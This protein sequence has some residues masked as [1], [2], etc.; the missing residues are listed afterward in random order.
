[1]RF[2]EIKMKT[3]TFE[4][5][6]NVE[7]EQ[8]RATLSRAKVLA[9][10]R[11]RGFDCERIFETV[12]RSCGP[13]H[14]LLLTSTVPNGQGGSTSDM[15]FLAVIDTDDDHRSRT[16]EWEV[17]DGCRIGVTYVTS[18]DVKRDLGLLAEFEALTPSA[19]KTVEGGMRRFHLHWR[20]LERLVNG[21]SFENGHP[22]E[23]HGPNLCR[24][25]LVRALCRADFCLAVVR[26][27]SVAGKPYAA[28][29][30]AR[31]AILSYIEAVLA[32]AG[33]VQSNSKWLIQRWTDILLP[34]S[35]SELRE[36]IE[37]QRKAATLGSMTPMS[38]AAAIDVELRQRI[39]FLTYEVE[40]TILCVR[41]P[42]NLAT[43]LTSTVTATG[44]NGVVWLASAAPW[45]DLVGKTVLEDTWKPSEAL[46]ALR[47]LQTGLLSCRISRL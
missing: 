1:M 27:A 16:V 36:A 14:Q 46:T 11:Q 28:A 7:P 21:F 22:F 40:D 26:I 35:L 5:Q 31:A 41:V 18:N 9:F 33:N 30:Y 38:V 8:S 15:D 37:R 39:T 19:A 24:W 34:D 17:V 42:M 25:A 4:T 12:S 3:P 47:G 6:S 43:P 10:G 20:N 44:T 32:M 45:H 13:V 23:G 29:A 2:D